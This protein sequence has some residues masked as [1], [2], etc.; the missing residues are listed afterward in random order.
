MTSV[1]MHMPIFYIYKSILSV[2]IS[3]PE[4]IQIRR[5]SVSTLHSLYTAFD[6]LKF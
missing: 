5:I 1:T 3:V 2:N 6:T 4:T